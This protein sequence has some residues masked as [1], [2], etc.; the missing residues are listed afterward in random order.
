MPMVKYT[1]IIANIMRSSRRDNRARVNDHPC[2]LVRQT[3]REP[4]RRNTGSTGTTHIRRSTD[5]NVVALTLPTIW[6]TTN[7]ALV[8]SPC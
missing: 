3:D 8:F 2:A 6:R 1:A 4:T 5:K 7:K